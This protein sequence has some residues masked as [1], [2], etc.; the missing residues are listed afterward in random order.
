MTQRMSTQEVIESVER[1]WARLM[2]AVDALSD[3]ATSLA[4]TE[5]GWTAKDVLG[6]L[7]H[8]GG[9]VNA[10]LV[11][12]ALK[13]G[14]PSQ[15][16]MP[17]LEPPAYVKNVEGRPSGEEWNAMAVD[18]SREVPLQQV[19]AELEAIVE[20]ILTRARSLSDEEMNSS[21]VIP[22]AGRRP[23]WNQIGTETFLHWPAHSE[24]IEAAART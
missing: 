6:H 14:E 8:W 4:V 10:G 17:P 16:E 7:I 20:S 22:W 3:G 12:Y 11:M 2:K 13:K 23:L 5:E 18:H 24:G 9:Q 15:D 1:E 21:E 19:K